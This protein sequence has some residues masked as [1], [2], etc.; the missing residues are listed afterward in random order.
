[1][2]EKISLRVLIIEDSEFDARILV[3]V[4]KQGGYEPQFQRV[5]TLVD[6]QTVL[7]EKDW[8]VILADYNLPTFDALAALKVL[9]DTGLDLPFIIVSGGIGEDTSARRSAGALAKVHLHLRRARSDR[10]AP[11]PLSLLSGQ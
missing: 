6:F 11:L 8:D 2:S 4:L 7:M 5:D 9:Q 3:N 1:M 10:D